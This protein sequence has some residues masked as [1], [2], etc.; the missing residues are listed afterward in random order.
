MQSATRSPVS[1]LDGAPPDVLAYEAELLAGS[2]GVL[3]AKALCR[4][5][6]WIH[7]QL[8]NT[9]VERRYYA[10]Q[11]LN[12]MLRTLGM[13]PTNAVPKLARRA[14]ARQKARGAAR[15]ALDDLL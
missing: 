14:V 2:Q 10:A 6:A 5:A 3:G 8:P 1:L 13:V 12:H 9:P 11:V 7:W 15:K 4:A